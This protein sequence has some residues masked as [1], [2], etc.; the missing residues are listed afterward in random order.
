MKIR[1]IFTIVI[2]I[3]LSADFFAQADSSVSNSAA[4]SSMQNKKREMPLWLKDA[5]DTEIIMLAF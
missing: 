5:R 3:F 1:N 4:E 2:L